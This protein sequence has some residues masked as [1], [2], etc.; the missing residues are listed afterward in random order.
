[1]FSL[2]EVVSW[3]SCAILRHEICIEKGERDVTTLAAYK[4][5]TLIVLLS[6]SHMFMC[7]K[8]RDEDARF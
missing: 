2:C 3:G 1:M 4:L 5:V 6:L 8:T 7:G